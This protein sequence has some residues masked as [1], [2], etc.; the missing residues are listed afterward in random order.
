MNL[1]SKILRIELELT[2]PFLE[3]AGLDL[4]RKGQDKIGELMYRAHRRKLIS[5]DV[6]LTNCKGCMISNG[7][8]SK[9]IILYLHG[10]GYVAGN[11]DYAKGYGSVLSSS[12]DISVFCIGYRLAPED[13]FPAALDDAF[14]AYTY[15]LENGYDSS[16]IILAGESAGGGLC[17][18]LCHLLKDRG[19]EM[20]LA[21]IAISPWVDL[22]QTGT[23][24]ELNEKADPSMSKNRLDFFAEEYCQGKDAR[25]RYISPLYGDL[26]GMPRSLIFAGGDE[27]L[28]DDA[29]RLDQKLR[30]SGTESQ[31]RIADRMWH[32][33]LLYRLKENSGD[34]HLIKSFIREVVNEQ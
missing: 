33:Y 28:L 29:R 1:S 25:D 21:I 11:L 32:A 31:I 13:P 10:G 14:E 3:N 18:C 27:I 19:L 30:A 23:S 22:T 9:H 7:T 16:H 8:P 12:N 6:G 20:P 34:E 5:Q 17:Y 26:S 2:K 15:L 4:H 24:Y